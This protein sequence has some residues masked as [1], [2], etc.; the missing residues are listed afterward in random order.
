MGE[1]P[2][3]VII[4]AWHS[5]PTIA[6]SI[7]S[8][9]ADAQ[10]GEVIV[11]D[12][13]STDDTVAVATS[14]DDGSGRLKI[15][16]Q[17]ANR[18][19]SAARNRAIREAKCP[20]VAILDSDDFLLPGRFAALLRAKGWD[21]LAD[22]IA[23]VPEPPDLTALALQV[24]QGDAVRPLTLE[25]FARRNISRRDQR[26]G[27]L[28][29]LKPVIAR[30]LLDRH[31]LSYAEDARLG[32]DFLLYAQAMAKGARF[33][34]AERCGY[35]AVERPDSLSG[36]HSMHDLATLAA[37]SRAVR[38]LLAKGSAADR[39]MADHARSVELKARHRQL[40]ADKA[41][42]GGVRAMLRLASRPRDVV[43]VMR[44]VLADKRALPCS[45]PPLRLLFDTADFPSDR[46]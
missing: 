21:I 3:T 13:A 41:D 27:E 38:T 30:S 8:A 45:A 6:A 2:V 7:R 26:R 4:A 42:M 20:Y 40:L 5:A 37:R 9:L 18:G 19:P 14:A 15:L 43:P 31:A 28:G 10:V 35:V 39:A 17:P 22:N 29:F 36:R 46:R 34:I 12:D 44:A 33:L 25:E 24:P 1:A 16:R 32:E 11:V 23:F